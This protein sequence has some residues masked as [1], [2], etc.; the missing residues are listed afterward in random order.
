MGLGESLLFAIVFVL[1]FAV[2]FLITVPLA[3][4]LV[5][6][7]ANYTP[8]GLQLDGEGGVQPHTGPVVNSYFAMFAR[9]KRLEGWTGLYKGL[10]PSLINS[11]IIVA[12]IAVLPGTPLAHTGGHK[13]YSAP[14]EGVWNRLAYS[15]FMMVISLPATVI[16]NR[17]ITTPYKLP[18]LNG[19]YSLRILLTASER[20]QP[21]L[22]FLTPGL[23]ASEVLRMLYVILIMDPLRLVI[24]PSG[25]KLSIVRVSVYLG[26]A[27]VST[28]IICPLEVMSTRLS[29]QRN[30]ATSGFA[31]V[32]QEDTEA[33]DVVYAG[34]EEDVI[35]LRNEDDPY[36]GFVD[37]AKRIVNEEGYTIL[38]RAWWLVL[39]P[40]MLLVTSP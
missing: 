27:F 2:L 23:M 24:L 28:A 4:V 37:C 22:L 36:V 17:A 25:S 40:L 34:A 39:V 7:R 20:R 15:L 31:P 32:A 26:L 8:K 35:G 9:V 10:M 19:A 18:W 21:W 30:H 5:R 38:F 13:K 1:S 33:N 11:L 14:I 16:T 29:I 12:F 6:F 3:G